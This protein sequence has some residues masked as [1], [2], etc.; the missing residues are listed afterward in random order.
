MT[1]KEYDI[2]V[3]Y[4]DLEQCHYDILTR[5]SLESEQEHK[6]INEES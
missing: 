2:T 6:R 3:E 5:L 4:D 1:E